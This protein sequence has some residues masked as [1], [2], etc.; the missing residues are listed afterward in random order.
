MPVQE[1]CVQT[2]L[3]VEEK[4]KEGLREEQKQAQ[5]GVNELCWTILRLDNLYNSFQF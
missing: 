4:M 5:A 3:E 1:E 2:C